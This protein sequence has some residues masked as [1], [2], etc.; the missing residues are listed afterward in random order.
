MRFLPLLLV[1]VLSG[2]FAA[3][4]PPKADLVLTNGKIVTLEAKQP[5]VTAL[6]AK[7]GRILALGSDQEIQRY[8]GPT[9]KRIDLKGALAV[10]GFIEGHGHFTSLG[11]SLRVL[12]L[13]KTKNWD[14]VLKL[15]GDAVKQARPGEWIL[16]RGWHQEK[17]DHPP[18]PN[19]QGLPLHAGLD[20]VAPDNLVM[21]EHASGHGL[22]VNGAVLTLLKIDRTTPDPA[23][24]QIVRDAQGEPIGMLWD[25]AMKPANHAYEESLESRSPRQASADFHQELRLAAD[26]AVKKGITTF[27]D[28][29]ESFAVLDAIKD[30]ADEDALPLRLYAMVDVTAGDADVA[31]LPEKEDYA[32]Y[33]GY[34]QLERYLPT[35]RILDDADGHFTVRAVGEVLSDGALGSHTAWFLKPYDDLPASSGIAVTTPET[36]Q[37]IA[38]LAL[39]DGFQLAVHAIGDRANRAALDVFQA[40]FA[41]HPDAKDLRWRIE[42]AQHLDPADIPRFGKLGVIASMQSVHACSDAPFVVKRLGEERAKAGAYVWRSLMQTGALIANGTDVPVEDEDPIPNFYCAVTR[43]AKSDG[44]PFYPGQAM[45]REEALRSYTWNNAYAIFAEKDLGSLAVGKRADV[46]VFSKD[47][48]SVP[49]QEILDAKVMY[50]VVGGRIVY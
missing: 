29:G 30:F 9:T 18:D 11:R 3:T 23:G 41:A 14:D 6:A 25:N 17:W 38:D 48:L 20:K 32:K 15:V 47:I 16:G 5:Q 33:D 10:P 31:G 13:T 34:T 39:K 43:R 24:G 4:P 19:V 37:R 50:T 8:V 45:T 42:H 49:E 35:H 27:V 26:D 7:D 21:L 2:T 44:T 46:T 36:V 1:T 12:N 22:F 28:D 40:E